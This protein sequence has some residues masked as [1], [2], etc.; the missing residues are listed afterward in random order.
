M[1]GWSFNRLFIV[2]F[3]S[4][5]ILFNLNVDVQIEMSFIA[6]ISYL[7]F[8]LANSTNLFQFGFPTS[9]TKCID[10]EKMMAK[11]CETESIG[12]SSISIIG[13]LFAERRMVPHG[14]LSNRANS[15]HTANL[16][17]AKI[18]FHPLEQFSKIFRHEILN[19]F[20]PIF[21]NFIEKERDG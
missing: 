18:I 13:R 16:T 1:V 19:H 12:L 5:A 4:S 20:L 17:T 7:F 15:W 10:I 21:T 11:M 2:D 6:I 9:F 3:F 14:W 8:S